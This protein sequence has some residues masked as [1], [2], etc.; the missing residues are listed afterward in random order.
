MPRPVSQEPRPG[1]PPPLP[2]GLAVITTH[3]NA[4]FD[5]F[6]SLLA[7]QRLYPHAKVVFPGSQEPTLRNFFIQSMVYLFNLVH[8]QDIPLEEVR[9]LVLVDTRQPGRIGRFAEILGRPDLAVHVYDHHPAAP[10]DVAGVYEACRLTGSTVTILAGILKD[11]SEPVTADEATVMALGI[12]EDT[13]SFTFSSTTP[14]DFTIMSWLLAK[15]ANL[16]M[17]SSLITREI[18]P[19]QVTLLNDLIQ[20]MAYHRVHGVEVAV[21]TLSVDEYVPDFAFLV[22]KLMKMENLEAVF[23]LARMGD[24]VFVVGRSR[25]PEVDVA[26]ILTDLGGGGHPYAASAALKDL[27]LPQ[28]ESRLMALLNARVKPRQKASD[29]M[30]APPITCAANV[31]IHEA[32]RLMTQYGVNALVVTAPADG[33]LSGFISRLV[34]EKALHHG[35]SELLVS[36]YMTP[37]PVTVGP[38]ADLAEI[39]QKIIEHKQRLLPVVKDRRILGVITRTDLLNILVAGTERLPEDRPGAEGRSQSQNRKVNKLLS[40]RLSPRIHELVLLLSRVADSAGVNAYLVGG[41]VRDLFLQQ[42]NEDLDV[43]VEGDG[44]AFAQAFSREA[45]G[46]VHAH[47]RFGT[48][49]VVLPDGGKVDVA[50]ARFEYYQSPGSL[51]VVET[52]S[53]MQDL[54]R[55]DCTV[56]TMVIQLNGENFGTLIDFFGARRDIKGKFIRVLHNLSFVEDPTRVFRAIRFEQRFGFTMGR[57]TAGLVE[58]SVRMNFFDRLPG[59]RIWTELRLIL[60]EDTVLAA[61][62]RMNEFGLLKFI[63]PS[64]R[65]DEAKEAI[66]VSVKKVLDWHDL[67]FL[68]DSYMKWAVQFLALL[69]GLDEAQAGQ[70]CLRL[71]LPEKFFQLFVGDRARA[72]LALQEVSAPEPRANSEIHRVLSPLPIELILYIMAVARREEARRRISLFFTQLR[73]TKV[74]VTGADLKSL[75][76]PSG[77]LYREILDAVFRARLDEKVRTREDE[78]ALVKEMAKARGYS[79][80]HP[81]ACRPGAG[82]HHP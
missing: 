60:A 59:K 64:L 38:E 45:G 69:H 68:D 5:A 51:P 24:R 53:L 28:V 35:L 73:G 55:R 37:D 14:D 23:A 21:C 34:V 44:I 12:Y 2:E 10:G 71:E 22:H 39:Q 62:R 79:T 36:E 46:R 58:N 11:L 74:Q 13:G 78:L 20:S 52:S 1:P 65:F 17:V 6:A 54:Y 32:G 80:D 26:N 41:F 67:L 4:D 19:Q 70:A 49:V 3:V 61:V 7:A 57:L 42:K 50:S 47:E 16:N 82:R 77:P 63:S 29:I 72:F 75:G 27:T 9:S 66:F 18:S 25:V 48:A 56:N 8:I 33:S 31:T 43:V 40:D 15:G 81:A 30:S 76:L